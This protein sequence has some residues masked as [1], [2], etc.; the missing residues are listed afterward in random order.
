MNKKFTLIELITVIVV[1]SILAAII[2][3][4]IS[5]LKEKSVKTAALVTDGE[6]QG[7][8]DRYHLLND[9]YPTLMQP[10]EESPQRVLLEENLYPNFLK[11]NLP[12]DIY[13]VDYN[14]SVF[15]S[16]LENCLSEIRDD[17]GKEDGNNKDDET[18][19]EYLPKEV[20][21]LDCSEAQA[22][23]YICIYT[24]SDLENINNNL[25]AKYILMNDIDLG[26]I[27]LWHPIA[28]YENSDVPFGGELNGNGYAIKNLDS[29]YGLDS[30]YEDEIGL[31]GEVAYAT[32]KNLIIENFKIQVELDSD[33]S[34]H[35]TNGG[36]I[37]L[38]WNTTLENI[39]VNGFNFDRTKPEELSYEDIY[40]EYIG[41]LVGIGDE[42]EIKDI[43]L[44]GINI[45]GTAFL[46]GMSGR[47]SESNL[48]NIYAN[49]I[50]IGDTEENL[51]YFYAENMGGIVGD[52]EHVN[53]KNIKIKNIQLV[54]TE[55]IGGFAGSMGA[56]RASEN[57]TVE[58]ISVQAEIKGM[59]LVGGLVGNT[60]SNI[61][62]SN[63][64][65]FA[66]IESLDE[67]N[68]DKYVY[69][70]GGL[71]GNNNEN[72][73][74]KNAT[75]RG[76]IKG[77]EGVAGVV[78]FS[79]GMT[80]LENVHSSVDLY[81]S[82]DADKNFNEYKDVGGLIGAISLGTE[83]YLTIKNS[84]YTGTIFDLKENDYYYPLVGMMNPYSSSE[85]IDTTNFIIENV[86]WSKTKNPTI[87]NSFGEGK[88]DSF[89]KK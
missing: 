47:L 45:Y 68:Y 54:G 42:M 35:G 7:A 17:I 83:E 40:V 70:F 64:D 60:G 11:K 69:S 38:S 22:Q 74:V 78:G 63:V 48:E 24:V 41:A 8:V 85:M 67:F 88:E 77:M 5:S 55:S 50:F 81:E 65:V 36:L 39:T 44:Q 76:A 15:R 49:D 66:N 82:K 61:T 53:A 18:G 10:T 4:N 89:F 32:I 56:F 34:Y 13:C 37:G 71:S 51:K 75:I 20:N 59:G 73:I 21:K 16:E 80:T 25:D 29:T 3:L 62:L 46:G 12:K 58:D 43:S 72:F 86:Y 84:S 19:E 1:I 14:G 33:R 28:H 26:E 57:Y 9:R 79:D 30:P 6:V 2:M 31:F 27:E 23:G 52:M 87:S